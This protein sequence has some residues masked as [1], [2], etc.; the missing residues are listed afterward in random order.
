M[1]ATNPPLAWLHVPA[2]ALFLPLAHTGK[3]G[4]WMVAEPLDPAQLHNAVPKAD[5]WLAEVDD[6]LAAGLITGA[7]RGLHF[8]LLVRPDPN[9]DPLLLQEFAI[10][11]LAILERDEEWSSDTSHDVGRLAIELNL[12][13]AAGDERLFR[14]GPPPTA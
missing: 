3:G 9:L 5:D 2:L 14:S 13:H 1:N 4:R 8:E 11:A 10:G 7:P 6:F 12:A